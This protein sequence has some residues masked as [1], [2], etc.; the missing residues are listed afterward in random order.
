VTSKIYYPSEPPVDVRKFT[1][2][3]QIYSLCGR[4]LFENSGHVINQSDLNIYSC[5]IIINFISLKD[6]VQLQC[7]KIH[8][9]PH[10]ALIIK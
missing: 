5:G 4:S 3:N 6:I 10:E 8:E 9:A 1:I 2:A 7:S